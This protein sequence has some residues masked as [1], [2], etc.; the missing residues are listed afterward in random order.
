MTESPR[1]D[2]VL[3]VDPGRFAETIRAA[4]AAGLT[5]TS[6]QPLIGTAA[7]TIAEDRIPLLRAVDGVEAVERDRT[8]R[9]P[10]PE[11]PVQ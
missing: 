2:V 11:S 1:V 3:S 8:V 4:Q 5:V 7:G 10:P 6:E 9:L